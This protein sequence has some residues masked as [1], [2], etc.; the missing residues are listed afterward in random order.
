[1]P[2]FGMCAINERPA[3][4]GPMTG[5]AKPLALERRERPMPLLSCCAGTRPFCIAHIAKDA[6]CAPPGQLSGLTGSLV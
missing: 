5:T 1:M 3:G 6:T 2:L 4:A